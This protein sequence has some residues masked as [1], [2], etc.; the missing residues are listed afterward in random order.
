LKRS[1]E[2]IKESKLTEEEAL[3]L[4]KKMKAGRFKKLKEQ[5]LV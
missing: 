1:N 2:L 3:E 4:S 5:G